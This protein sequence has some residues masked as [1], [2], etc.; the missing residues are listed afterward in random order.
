MINYNLNTEDLDNEKDLGLLYFDA[1]TED[2]ALE[3]MKMLIDVFNSEYEWK[4]MFTI[5]DVSDRLKSGH[6]L[7]LLVL[8]NLPI[9]YVWFRK[10][11]DNSVYLYNLYVTKLTKRTHFVPL[12]FVNKVCSEMLKFYSDIQ[13]ECE[14]W[15]SHAQTVFLYNGFKA[16]NSN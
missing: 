6:V 16:Q 1:T 10:I 9:G 2:Y 12:W 11:D 14:D 15:N 7:F 3:Y 8:R 13:C 5:D 4:E